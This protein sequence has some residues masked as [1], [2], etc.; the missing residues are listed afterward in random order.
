MAG[1]NENICQKSPLN[2][3]LFG[4]KLC[5]TYYFLLASIVNEAPGSQSNWLNLTI[6]LDTFD[7]RI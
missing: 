3:L 2:V 6:I 4:L 1:L 5:K 7:W